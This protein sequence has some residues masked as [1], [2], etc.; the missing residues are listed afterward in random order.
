[1]H[2]VDMKLA[3][4]TIII[5]ILLN[6]VLPLLLKPLA[7]YEEVKPPNG[8][9]HLSLKGQF[10]HMMVHHNQVQFTSSLIVALIVFSSIS[11]ASYSK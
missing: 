6:I 5:S 7:T 9:A 10:M 4:H 1:M 3:K 2:K 11:L 8:A